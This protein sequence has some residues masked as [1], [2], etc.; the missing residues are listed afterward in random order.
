MSEPR[1]FKLAAPIQAYGEE[2]RE[3]RMR[4]PSTADVRAINAVPYVFSKE[5]GGV[6][7]LVPEVCARYISRLAQ[8][9]LSAVDQL[10]LGDFHSLA[11]EVANYFLQQ[12]MVE[13]QSPD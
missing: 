2:M 9:P 4:D 10:A 3:L 8:I 5:A 13:D 7:T 12:L 11:W 1:V 6:P